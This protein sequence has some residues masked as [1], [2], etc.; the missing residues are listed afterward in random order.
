MS[1]LG[2]YFHSRPNQN[3]YDPKKTKFLGVFEQ[4]DKFYLATP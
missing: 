3:G 4:N 2:N 1:L